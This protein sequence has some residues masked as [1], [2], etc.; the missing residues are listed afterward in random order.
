MPRALGALPTALGTRMKPPLNA[1]VL[2]LAVARLR[3]HGVVSPPGARRLHLR[4]DD[5]SELDVVSQR[6]DDGWLATATLCRGGKSVYGQ[7]CVPTTT[8][9]QAEALAVAALADLQA[10]GSSLT[11][12][13]RVA[14]ER[15]RR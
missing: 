10:L 2:P 6:K 9:I 14:A 11:I 5:D 4:L 8:S 3:G 1:Y 13:I 7:S 12:S 15:P